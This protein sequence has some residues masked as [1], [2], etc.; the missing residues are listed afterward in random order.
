MDESHASVLPPP[1]S[2]PSE[3]TP[4]A[5]KAENVIPTARRANSLIPDARRAAQP[6]DCVRRLPGDGGGAGAGVDCGEAEEEGAGVGAL[7]PL[8]PSPPSVILGIPTVPRP[9]GV[10][11]LEETLDAVLSQEP[12]EFDHCTISILVLNVH[13]EG[14]TAFDKARKAHEGKPGVIFLTMQEAVDAQ[15]LPI[16]VGDGGPLPLRVNRKAL[17]TT[18]V[19]KQTRDLVYLLRAAAV[20]ADHYLF[21]EDDMRLCAGGA[22]AIGRMLVKAHSYHADWI[23][24]RASFGM[25]GIL[26]Q[27]RDVLPFA[28]YLELHQQRRPPDHLVVEWFAGETPESLALKAGREHMAFRYNI[29]EH[30]GSVSTLR[31]KLSPAYPSCFEELTTK[32]LFAVEAFDFAHC[33]SDDMS[34]CAVP[35]GA[36]TGFPR[37]DWPTLHQDQKQM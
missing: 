9:R 31:G 32:T 2:L 27:E 5:R 36:K 20:R 29:F 22:A 11:Y 18:K 12:S 24:I 34:P 6:P 4:D 7:V 28:S 8:L 16:K 15:G 35:D 10:S 26:I 33:P 21:M 37:I 30:L 17:P 23:A 13:G 3:N 19:R 14:H 1:N 25:N